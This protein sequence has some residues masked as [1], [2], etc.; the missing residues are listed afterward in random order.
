VLLVNEMSVHYLFLLVTFAINI[1]MLATWCVL[2]A[3]IL[4]HTERDRERQ[5]PSGAD[6]VNA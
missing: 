2:A 1:I 5:R 3:A 6:G 4:A